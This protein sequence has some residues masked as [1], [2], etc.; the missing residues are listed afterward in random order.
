MDLNGILALTSNRKPKSMEPSL[1]PSEVASLGASSASDELLIQA[2]AKLDRVA[3]GI[4]VGIL[5]GFSVLA[6][7][8]ILVIKGGNQVGP[9]LGLLS[10][11]FIGYS[12]SLQ[13]SVIGLTYGFIS[14]FIIGWLM[15]FLRNLFVS[16]Y[17]HAARLR[18]GMSS[19]NDFLDNP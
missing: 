1:T 9:N 14:G 19:L 2:L 6:A 8:V 7:T 12:V 11:Y 3:L 15:A 4:A 13:G 18:A 16:A 10:Q 5:F 17:L